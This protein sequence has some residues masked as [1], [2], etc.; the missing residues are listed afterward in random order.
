MKLYSLNSV[1]LFTSLHSQWDFFIGLDPTHGS[2]N[3]QSQ[4][5]AQS[6]ALA[7]LDGETVV[8]A[9]D[10]TTTLQSGQNRDS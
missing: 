3:Y 4:S 6:K 1:S 5:D 2:V 7:Y 8:L 9:V 10:N